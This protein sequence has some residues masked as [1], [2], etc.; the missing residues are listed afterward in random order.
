LTLL[1]LLEVAEAH[2]EPVA[3]V[4]DVRDDVLDVGVAPLGDA[5]RP[6]DHEARVVEAASES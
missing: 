4:V 5:P 6:R 2:D 1:G 3:G